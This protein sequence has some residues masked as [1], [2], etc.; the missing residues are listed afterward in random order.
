M[1]INKLSFFV[2]LSFS[3]LFS[4]CL[5]DK[6]E[7][8]VTYTKRVPILKNMED[9][10]IDISFQAPRELVQPGKIYYYNEHLFINEQKEGVHV[11][12]NSNPSAPVNLGFL[13]IPG[14]VDIAIK[15]GILYADN[16]IDL[17]A[18]NI[19]TL[20]NPVLV[21]RVE[22]IYPIYNINQEG[23]L[24]DYKFEEVTEMR[25][26]D[27]DGVSFPNQFE[28]DVAVVFDANSSGSSSGTGGSLARFSIY[29][30]YLYS[31]DYTELHVFDISQ[32]ENPTEVNRVSIGWEI[33]TIFSYTDKLFIGSTSGMFIYDA[34]DP[35]NPNYLSEYSHLYACD[36]VYVKEPYAYVTLRDGNAWC[37]ENDNQLDLVNITDMTN[38]Y[39]EKSF[40]MDNPHGLGI[41]GD[42]LF[43]CEGDAGL[44][45]FDIADP[46][47]LDERLLSDL[48]NI[49]SFDVIALPGADD[50]LLVIGDDGFYQY[51]AQDPANLQLLS[52]IP[53]RR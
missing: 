15:N 47:T 36:P 45:T 30:D 34:A 32:I 51:N 24:V 43:I 35:V 8:E 52:H 19:T 28:D 14:N 27:I 37:A 23:L 48:K 53:V 49:T 20:T 13:P 22:G 1:K 25:E 39:L 18:I 5:K 29:Q 11:F 10:R 4:S 33:E 2:I 7:R 12:D 9:V 41:K 40:P 38:I 3:F 17:I 44:K 16:Y 31:I 26:C 50:L 21:K 42:N 46:L 6:C